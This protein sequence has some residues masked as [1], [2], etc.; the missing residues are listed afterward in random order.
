MVV[1]SC[2]LHGPRYIVL[3]PGHLRNIIKCYGVFQISANHAGLGKGYSDPPWCMALE[4][5]KE[6]SIAKTV[7]KQMAE[8]HSK[9]YTVSER[10]DNPRD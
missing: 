10:E 1:S 7:Y 3:N 2:D 8:V 5:C 4:L 9:V 6:G